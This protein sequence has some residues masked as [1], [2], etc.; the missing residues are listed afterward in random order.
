MKNTMKSNYTEIWATPIAEYWLE[1]YSLHEELLNIVNDVEWN[2]DDTM[3]LFSK[4]CRFSEWVLHCVEDY[5]ARFN[6]PMKYC[7]IQRGWCTTQH[8][9]HDNFIH[10][11]YT[12]DIA[13]VYYLDTVP[14]HPPLEILDPR[15][16]HN[17]NMCHRKM[18][19]GN[20]ASGFSSIQIKP[21]TYKL[22]MHPGYLRHGVT[23]N[24]TNIPRS[25]VA[26]NILTKRDHSV[27]MVTSS[28]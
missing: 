17:F 22:V 18:A 24:L 13:A 8:P 9:L 25:A 10:T 5:V 27:K 16:G 28:Y 14:E 23:H 4:P 21:E 1:D 20:I 12:A 11:H 3:N 2:G 7:E 6:F 15:P 19:D 26:M